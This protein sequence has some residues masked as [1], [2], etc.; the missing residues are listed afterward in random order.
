MGQ[1]FKQQ[2]LFN[3]PHAREKIVFERRLVPHAM[4]VQLEVEKVVVNNNKNNLMDVN[5]VGFQLLS[6]SPPQNIST[7]IPCQSLSTGKSQLENYGQLVL[8]VIRSFPMFAGKARNEHLRP[9]RT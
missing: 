6:R 9:F 5:R 3:D 2:Q 1:C 7:S 4:S 8:S